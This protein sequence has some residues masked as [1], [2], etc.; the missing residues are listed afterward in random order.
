M[1]IESSFALAMAVLCAPALAGDVAWKFKAG[2]TY[3]WEGTTEF[4]YTQEERPAPTGGTTFRAGPPTTVGDPQWETITLKATVLAVDP[5]GAGRLEFSVEAVHIET[6]FDTG[7][8]HAE[9][10]S[11]KSKETDVAGYKRYQAIL[12]NKF[13]AVIGPDGA[14][15]D[16]QGAEWA[17]AAATVAETNKGTSNSIARIEKAAA[18]THDPTPP[19][20]WLSLLFGTTPERK[21]GWTR[22]L[23]LPQEE[24]LSWRADNTEQ[25]GPTVCAKVKLESVDKKRL[26]K[27][28]SVKV[29]KGSGGNEL[30][31]FALALCQAARKK[32][33]VWFSRGLGCLVKAD[34][35]AATEYS[36]GLRLTLTHFKW[37]L[38]LKERGSV[39]VA[40]GSAGETP[41]K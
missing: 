35:E 28:E 7:G 30:G 21:A 10:D 26:V 41:T 14:V 34:I 4:H 12:G 18:E 8:E 13:V 27:A 17:R 22:A 37:G 1:R 20:V 40:P 6:R 32:G 29:E 33:T 3:T 25:I 36:D 31:D 19:S 38:E 23:H 9:W 39:P 24:T 15:R 2:S 5:D 16:V 11:S